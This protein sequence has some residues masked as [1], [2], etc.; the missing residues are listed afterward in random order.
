MAS[1]AARIVSHQLAT[2]L[3]SL[4]TQSY[5]PDEIRV[6]MATDARETWESYLSS[7]SGS[8]CKKHLAGGI[9]VKIIPYFVEDIGPAT[10]FVYALTD[11]VAK[12]DLDRPVVILGECGDDAALLTI[13]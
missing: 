9:Q 13:R 7:T 8:W 3:K 1:T 6:Y 10:K 2:T 12:G 5:G 11:L 4:V